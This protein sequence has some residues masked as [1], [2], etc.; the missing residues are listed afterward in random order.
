LFLFFNQVF[1]LGF[2]FYPATKMSSAKFSAFFKF[3]GASKSHRIC[4]NVVRVSNSL[5]LGEMPNFSAS[6]P[7]LSYLHIGLWSR[8]AG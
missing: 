8:S 6:H 3:Q 2:N 7:D 1:S 5:D 4:E